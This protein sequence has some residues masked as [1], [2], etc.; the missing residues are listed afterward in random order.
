MT[1]VRHS[2][3]KMNYVT[4]VVNLDKNPNILIGIKKSLDKNSYICKPQ[5]KRLSVS[6]FDQDKSITK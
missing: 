4:N 5:T 3:K 6:F 2:H 1:Q